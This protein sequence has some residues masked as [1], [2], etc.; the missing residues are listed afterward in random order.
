M[1]LEGKN[2][3]YSTET[4]FNY[5]AGQELEWTILDQYKV[6][7]GLSDA[8]NQQ[9]STDIFSLDP[10]TPNNDTENS[11]KAK[12]DVNKLPNWS[13]EYKLKI[14]LKDASGGPEAL[15]STAADVSCSLT[16]NIA[17]S[18]EDVWR[19]SVRTPNTYGP[20]VDATATVNVVTSPT[21]FTITGLTGVNV[22]NQAVPLN[23]NPWMP[24]WCVSGSPCWPGTIQ[25]P[26]LPKAALD[27]PYTGQT[28]IDAAGNIITPFYINNPQEGAD[29]INADT[30]V[31]IGKVDTV[32]YDNPVCEQCEGQFSSTATITTQGNVT[33]APGDNIKFQSGRWEVSL[34]NGHGITYTGPMHYNSSQI[35]TLQSNNVSLI[36]ANGWLTNLELCP[37]ADCEGTPW[38]YATQ[39]VEESFKFYSAIN[40]EWLYGWDGGCNNYSC[41]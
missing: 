12:V 2:G 7:P 20:Y 17:G 39:Q 8:I 29:I 36:A 26:I 27:N 19:T 4:G 41:S 28:V 22:F 11:G 25:G 5:L 23:Q 16:I 13:G 14:G 31:T 38:E 1:T 40:F 21:V 33:I 18:L 32:E 30:G 37:G 24:G 6:N 35:C 3:A 15:P 34:V 9:F 10:F